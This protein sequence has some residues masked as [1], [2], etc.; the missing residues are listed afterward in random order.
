MIVVIVAFVLVFGK[1]VKLDINDD[2]AIGHC[3]GHGKSNGYTNENHTYQNGSTLSK[4]ENNDFTTE[5]KPL[6][7]TTTPCYV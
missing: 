1:T 7:S 5:A 3:N 4:Q 2:H 6:L